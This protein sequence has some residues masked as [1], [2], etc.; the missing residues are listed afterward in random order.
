MKIYLRKK[1]HTGLDAMLLSALRQAL[2]LAEMR[3][4][5]PNF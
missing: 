5:F 2:T 3:F 1:N 4:D